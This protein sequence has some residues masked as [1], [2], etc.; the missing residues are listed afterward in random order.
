MTVHKNSVLVLNLSNSVEINIRGGK[1]PGR[2]TL[3]EEDVE[4]FKGTI[5]SFW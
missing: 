4:L 2:N 1:L 5:F 3:L